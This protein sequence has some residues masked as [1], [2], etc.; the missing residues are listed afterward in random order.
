MTTILGKCFRSDSFVTNPRIPR[1]TIQRECPCIFLLITTYGNTNQQH[2]PHV[3]SYESMLTCQFTTRAC[4][5]YLKFLKSKGSECRSTK[6]GA[7]TVFEKCPAVAGSR[8]ALQLIPEKRI[9]MNRSNH[10]ARMPVYCCVLSTP[11]CVRISHSGKT[12]NHK[13]YA[14]RVNNCN[15]LTA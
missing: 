10:M 6:Q 14:T 15:R 11:P 8:H 3:L 12:V 4:L 9:K 5:K 7:D 13:K 1:L 2:R